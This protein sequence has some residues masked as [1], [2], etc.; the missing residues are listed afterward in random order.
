[1]QAYASQ[2]TT[3]LTPLTRLWLGAIWAE[4]ACAIICLLG[5]MW[6]DPGTVKRSPQTCYPMPELVSER[7]RNGRPLD[8]VG[9]VHEVRVRRCCRARRR[10][11]A[12]FSCAGPLARARFV[13][14][15]HRG[16]RPQAERIWYS[17]NWGV[18]VI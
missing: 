12:R 18:W 5:L 14:R 15:R 13:H 17:S 10:M 9:N 2:T 8:G 1:M 6:G 16:E 4:A 11:R 7:L 3:P